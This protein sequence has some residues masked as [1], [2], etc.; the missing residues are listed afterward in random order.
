[1][2]MTSRQESG[3]ETQH[4]SDRSG[5]DESGLFEHSGSRRFA[6]AGAGR[7]VSGQGEGWSWQLVP[8]VGGGLVEGQKQ[9][10]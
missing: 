8:E 2:L 6:E 5:P 7:G 10:T 3:G 1:M 4:A 9:N